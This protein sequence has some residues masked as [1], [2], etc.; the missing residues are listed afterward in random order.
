MANGHRSV[1][2]F[3][4]LDRVLIAS[5]FSDLL[6]KKRCLP[7]RTYPLHT[8][9]ESQN[10]TV[11]QNDPNQIIVGSTVILRCEEN[12]QF[13]TTSNHSLL[14]HC[15]TDGTWTPM[16]SCRC[17]ESLLWGK[18]T[19]VAL[20]RLDAQTT[21]DYSKLYLPARSRITRMNFQFSE[22]NRQLHTVSQMARRPFDRLS[23]ARVELFC[24]FAIV[25]HLLF[26][27][28]VSP[29]EHNLFAVDA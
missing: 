4:G 22:T 25:V 9:V 2:A 16:L 20:D 8:V 3:V 26:S 19:I 11:F 17:E 14:L 27:S 6:A 21:C 1:N 29:E 24:I 15:R 28:Y 23:W 12:Y 13:E 7:I 5:L 18:R 10:I